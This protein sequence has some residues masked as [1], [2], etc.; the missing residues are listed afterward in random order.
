MKKTLQALEQKRKDVAALRHVRIA[1][2]PPFMA[3]HLERSAFI[4]GEA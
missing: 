1:R 2:R 4:D 3:N